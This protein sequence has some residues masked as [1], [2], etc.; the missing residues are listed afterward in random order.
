[1]TFQRDEEFLNRLMAPIQ[2]LRSMV[3]GNPGPVEHLHG[4]TIGAILVGNSQYVVAF[5]DGKV[6]LG[7][8]PAHMA[9]RKIFTVDHHSRLLISGSPILGKEYA[10]AL[11]SWIGYAEDTGR[12]ML[13]RAKANALAGMLFRGFGLAGAGLVCAPILATYDYAG[14]RCARIFPLGVEGSEIA[15][16]NFAT[17]GSGGNIDI[18]LRDRYAKAGETT[19]SPDD[20]IALAREMIKLVPDYDSFSGGKASVDLIGPEGARTIQ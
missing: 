3:P 19:M 6:S 7:N 16:V 4:T 10:S 5:S 17:G 8:K 14:K 2:E 18:L 12:P 13:A 9:Y 11:R 1:M 20:G 15:D